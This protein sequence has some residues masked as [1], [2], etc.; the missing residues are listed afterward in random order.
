[1]LGTA[2]GDRVLRS[3]PRQ[4]RGASTEHIAERPLLT[5]PQVTALTNALPEHAFATVTSPNP[6]ARRF[7]RHV[8]TSAGMISVSSRPPRPGEMC[9]RSKPSCSRRVRGR[10][11]ARSCTD[12]DVLADPNE[13]DTS[14]GSAARVGDSR[15][16]NPLTTLNRAATSVT[17][18]STSSAARVRSLVV[19][20]APMTMSPYGGPTAPQVARR[21]IR[22]HRVGSGVWRPFSA[23]VPRSP[24]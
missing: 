24:A 5:V 7:E 21:L 1:M 8:R 15:W 14:L 16:T 13:P 3:D 10:G 9:S 2:V 6:A 17:V 23:A 20:A 22:T 19:L 18:S 12:A 4:I 11:P